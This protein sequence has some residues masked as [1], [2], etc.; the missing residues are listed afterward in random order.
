MQDNIIYNLNKK[1]A[2]EFLNITRPT[3]DLWIKNWED[4]ENKPYKIMPSSKYKK[5]KFSKELLKN[6]L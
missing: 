6:Y 5:F 3:L 1:Q 2:A 4:K